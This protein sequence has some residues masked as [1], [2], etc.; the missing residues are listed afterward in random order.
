MQCQR[1]KHARLNHAGCKHGSNG[2]SLDDS[3]SCTFAY[4][5]TVSKQD[6][7]ALARRQDGLVP[8]T[9][10]CDAFKLKLTEFAYGKGACEEWQRV[11][12]ERREE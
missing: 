3:S 6:S 12:G 10:M 7:C 2:H 1:S 11:V 9:S 5:S 4:T 8:L